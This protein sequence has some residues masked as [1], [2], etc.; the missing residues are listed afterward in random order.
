MSS[1]FVHKLFI[2]WRSYVSAAIYNPKTGNNTPRLPS[3]KTI[4]RD[5][6]GHPKLILTLF[7]LYLSRDMTKSNKMTVRPVKTQISLDIRPA[8]S[9][10]SLWAQWVAKDPR[11][12]QVDSEDSDLTG[13]VPRLIW[14]FAGR[15]LV[16]FVLSCRGSLILDRPL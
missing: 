12:L 9:E 1:A 14:V 2:N 16:L 13:R 10:S 7:L 11:L 3:C 5:F 8:R 6:R 4:T 15:T